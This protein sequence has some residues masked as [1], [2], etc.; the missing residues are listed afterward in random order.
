MSVSMYLTRRMVLGSWRG[1]FYVLVFLAVS[2]SLLFRHGGW[3]ALIG[4]T[5]LLTMV[6]LVLWRIRAS[7]RKKYA[8][9]FRNKEALTYTM[10]ETNF[11]IHGESFHL[12]HPWEAIKK[13]ERWKEHYLIYP[14]QWNAHAIGKTAFGPGQEQL[15]TD[16]LDRVKPGWR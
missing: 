13:V 7:L 9:S 10:T 15:F 14:S 12:D 8:E 16:L 6:A 5:F 4:A 1:I 2:T 11:D 3:S